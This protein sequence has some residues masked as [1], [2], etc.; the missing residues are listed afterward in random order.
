MAQHRQL[1]EEPA[2][3]VDP[4]SGQK[5]E[6]LPTYSCN[7]THGEKANGPLVYV[8][9]GLPEDYDELDRLGISVKASSCPRAVR[10]LLA[11][12]QA[13]GGGRARRRRLPH[14][15]G[16]PATTATPGWRQV[17]QG[18]MRPKD[19]VQRGSVMDFLFSNPGD[20]LTPG[21]GAT[22]RRRGSR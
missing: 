16:T 8:N 22:K 9:Y 4:T 19:G 17:P 3:V 5:A 1:L 15:L 12:H 6:Q 2:L 21:V 7:C 18:P 11:R 10:P 20:P 13:E 14:L